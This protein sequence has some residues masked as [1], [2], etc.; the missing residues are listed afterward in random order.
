MTPISSTFRN[1][2]GS[3]TKL[4][5]TQITTSTTKAVPTTPITLEGT[6]PR[7][8]VNE[9]SVRDWELMLSPGRSQEQGR[10]VGGGLAPSPEPVLRDRRYVPRAASTFSGFG[11]SV[12]S[13]TSLSVAL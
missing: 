4:P 13:V 1:S 8:A 11:E 2:P 5:I 12:F 3:W 10:T 9:E 6:S 7:R